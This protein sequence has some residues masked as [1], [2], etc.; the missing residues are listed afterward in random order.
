MVYQIDLNYGKSEEKSS[1]KQAYEKIMKEI[2]D[3][4]NENV[5]DDD[6]KTNT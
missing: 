6:K 1:N 5:S 4:K 3:E 2:N